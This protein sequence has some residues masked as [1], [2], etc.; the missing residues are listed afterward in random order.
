MA[1]KNKIK[2]EYPE[3]IYRP[4][5][6]EEAYQ[7]CVGKDI[8]IYDEHHGTATRIRKATAAAIDHYMDGYSTIIIL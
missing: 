8:I 2:A 6:N 5:H 7:Q 3:V 1:D 4:G